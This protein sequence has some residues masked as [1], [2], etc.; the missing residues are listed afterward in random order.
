LLRVVCE[1][2]D[3]HWKLGSLCIVKHQLRGIYLRLFDVQPLLLHKVFWVDGETFGQGRRTRKGSQSGRCRRTGL[4]HAQMGN[5]M[6]HLL[7]RMDVDHVHGCKLRCQRGRRTWHGNLD[8]WLLLGVSLVLLL[9]LQRRSG[10]RTGGGGG[11]GSGG[12]FALL[13]GEGK[14]R[15]MGVT[16]DFSKE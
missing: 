14:R 11:G 2:E 9:P 6:N 8:A 4:V 15:R 3:G 16:H 5:K 10:G 12:I 1:K 7:H 13:I